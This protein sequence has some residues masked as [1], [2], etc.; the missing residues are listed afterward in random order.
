M[1]LFKNLQPIFKWL[2]S[3]SQ[4]IASPVGSSA[5]S[6]HTKYEVKNNVAI[7]TLDSPNVKV[8]LV[9]LNLL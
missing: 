8:Y 3:G 1:S 2:V 9:D 7:I 5:A 4:Q 6:M